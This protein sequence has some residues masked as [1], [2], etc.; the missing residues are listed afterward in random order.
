MKIT[1]LSS[2]LILFGA[3]ML[4]AGYS[5]A[6]TIILRSGNGIV[7]GNDSQVSMSI[8]PADSEF[9]AAFTSVDF[10]NSR[11]GYDAFIIAPHSAWVNALAGDDTSQWISTS[12]NGVIEGGTALYAISF[13]LED[14]FDSATLD[15]HFIVDNYLGGSINQGVY[16]NG[17][18]ISGN[19]VMGNFMD[20]TVITRADIGSLLVSGEN[21]LYINATDVGGPS[22]LIFR[23][24]IETKSA[25]IPE[26]DTVALLGTGLAGFLLTVRFSSGKIKIPV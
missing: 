24:T 26:P 9:S 20:E 13:N 2:A 16:L 5:Y 19:S 6:E 14:S 7:G 8:G 4:A 15:L 23:A 1:K 18:A 3:L 17:I 12:S 11:N 22:G 25:P 21:T 10:Q